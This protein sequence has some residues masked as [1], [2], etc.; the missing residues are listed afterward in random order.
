[1]K[2]DDGFQRGVPQDDA[3]DLSLL[4]PMDEDLDLSLGG[5]EILLVPCGGRAL[6]TDGYKPFHPIG[7]L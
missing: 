7:A 1:V 6:G 2:E 3:A 5:N 4:Q